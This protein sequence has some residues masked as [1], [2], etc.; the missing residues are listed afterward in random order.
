MSIKNKTNQYTITPNRAQ[1]ILIY[2]DEQLVYNTSKKVYNTNISKINQKLRLC[3]IIQSTSKLYISIYKIKKNGLKYYLRLNLNESTVIN[4][5]HDKGGIYQYS[6]LDCIDK[7]ALFIFG[8]K[9]Q[10][11]HNKW[12]H[13]LKTSISKNIIYDSILQTYE[14][15]LS[16]I[17]IKNRENNSVTKNLATISTIHNTNNSSNKVNIVINNEINENIDSTDKLTTIL[18][19]T[20]SSNI[21]NKTNEI[22]ENSSIITDVTIEMYNKSTVILNYCN[23][24]EIIYV[25]LIS[26]IYCQLYNVY[27]INNNQLYYIN[28]IHNRLS[29][30]MKDYIQLYDILSNHITIITMLL[31]MELYGLMKST[32]LFITLDVFLIILILFSIFI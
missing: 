8:N 30:S 31:I 21:L 17:K 29:D 18:L 16:N 19:A 15:N 10:E 27:V 14:C 7:D 23:L 4:A 20:N 2:K 9:S 22:T 28:T 1:H 11:N 5:Y 25:I 3:E 6:I 12:I 32:I 24:I 13:N 26:I